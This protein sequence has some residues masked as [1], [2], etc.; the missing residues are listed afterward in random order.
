M[1]R[2]VAQLNTEHFRNQLA[3]EKDRSQTARSE[4]APR[5]GRGQA[6]RDRDP[7]EEGPVELES[8]PAP[9]LRH[10]PGLSP[11]DNP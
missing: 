9:L 3:E 6:R 2:T 4:A 5:R 10:G 7:E 11:G 8:A 1:D